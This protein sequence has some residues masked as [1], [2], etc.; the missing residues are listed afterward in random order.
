MK[1]SVLSPPA[2][3]ER[4]GEE[5]DP[6]A[7]I[8][9]AMLPEIIAKITA[10]LVGILNPLPVNYPPLSSR[11]TGGVVEV[12]RGR[13]EPADS[14]KPTADKAKAAVERPPPSKGGGRK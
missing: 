10:E 7:P 5:E 14:P 4:T 3:K 9:R 12:R 11:L 8:T 6:W 2:Q 13:G 1:L